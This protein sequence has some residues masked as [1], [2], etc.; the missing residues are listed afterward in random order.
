MTSTD[1]N[2]YLRETMGEDFTARHFRT[3]HASAI[4]FGLLAGAQGPVGLKALLDTVSERLGNT[5]AIA[6]K[7]YIHPA[8]LALVERQEEWRAGLQLPRATQWLSRDERG[9]L[10]LL[11]EAPGA[12]EILSPGASPSRADRARGRAGSRRG[13]GA[14]SA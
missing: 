9:L 13:A 5:P 3:W 10:L 2:S 12:A 7:S 1:V 14:A 11:E 6:R 8:V 4:A